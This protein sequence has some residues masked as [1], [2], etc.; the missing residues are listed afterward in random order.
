MQF[1]EH[2][3]GHQAKKILTFEDARLGAR[4]YL[5]KFLFNTFQAG[6]QQGLT[7]DEN[8]RAFDEIHLVPRAGNAFESRSMARTI[9]GHDLSM[10]V[11]LA[12]VGAL[13]LGRPS[14]GEVAAAR[15]AG[16]AGTALSVSAF[17]GYAIEDVTRA[18]TGPVFCQLNLFGDRQSGESIVE[19]AKRAGCG[20]LVVVVDNLAPGGN[21]E[22][23]RRKRAYTPSDLSPLE[24]VRTAPQLLPRLPWLAAFIKDGMPAF[25]PMALDSNGNPM[26]I[27]DA[28]AAQRVNILTW[29][30]FSWIRKQWTGALVVKGIMRPDD[31]L[32]ARDLGANAIVVSNHGGNHID[33]AL[34]SIRVLPSIAAAVAGDMEIILDSGV[35]RGSDVVKALAL[36]A[37]AV[38]VGR[39]Y[40]YALMAAGEAG[41]RRMLEILREG[42]DVTLASLGCAG[43][44]ALDPSFVEIPAHWGVRP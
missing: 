3:A 16:A 43:I 20:A 32:R 30:D 18:A 40:V 6:T 8:G 39:A 17:A 41:V 31:A 27:V 38:Q 7:A 26:K 1:S 25:A 19:R 29:D 4:R 24:A 11:M 35:R 21:R 37:D 33:G 36:G 44:D 15:A 10:P 9:L 12:P 13:R 23:P 14:E 22:Q 5:P 34:P 2:L 28:L 42:I